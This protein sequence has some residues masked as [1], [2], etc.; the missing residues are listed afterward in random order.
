MD[1]NAYSLAWLRG[2]DFFLQALEESLESSQD[3]P[4]ARA[5]CALLLEVLRRE[6]RYADAYDYWRAL[7]AFWEWVDVFPEERLPHAL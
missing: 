6:P 3:E 2:D 4:R 1:G 5:N 7:E